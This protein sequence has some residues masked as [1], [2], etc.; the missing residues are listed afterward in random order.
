M[1]KLTDKYFKDWEA[2]VFGFGYGTGE[3][4]TLNTLKDFFSLLDQGCYDFK[5]LE[6]KLSPS[7][8]WL[9]INI[10]CHADIIEYGSSP[11]FGWLNNGKGN[12]LRDYLKRNSVDKLYEICMKEDE[13]S[14]CTES[15]CNCGDGQINKKCS[16]PLF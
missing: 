14:Y 15:Y 11:R 12:L 2:V 1:E 4:H 10:L 9:L 8:T 13:H 6:E 16:N 3:K 5:V 7:I